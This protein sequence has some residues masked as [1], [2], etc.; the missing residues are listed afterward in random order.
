MTADSPEPAVAEAAEV[1]WRAI[2]ER[3]FLRL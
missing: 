2:V 3:C 1:C